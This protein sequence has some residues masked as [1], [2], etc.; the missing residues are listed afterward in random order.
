MDVFA[1]GVNIQDL[2]L[3]TRVR[4]LSPPTGS[5]PPYA[6]VL[7]ARDTLTRDYVTGSFV[8]A[9]IGSDGGIALGYSIDNAVNGPETVADIAP[10]IGTGL[11]FVAEDVNLQ[12]D[13]VG[14]QARFTVWGASQPKPQSPQLVG[15]LPNGL[16]KS[17]RS[18]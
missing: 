13:I 4:G 17:G 15:T 12:L 6:I 9:G 7:T 1:D 10:R 3:R 8:W 2:S 16:A 11:N 14:N 18:Y 5:N